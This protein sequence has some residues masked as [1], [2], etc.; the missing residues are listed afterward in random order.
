VG[1]RV[2]RRMARGR[3]CAHK[4]D[5]AS[6]CRVG[7]RRLCP[8]AYDPPAVRSAGAASWT[9]VPQGW[10]H[11]TWHTCCP[12]VLPQSRS[13]RIFCASIC[14][15]ARPT[16]PHHRGFTIRSHGWLRWRSCAWARLH[17]QA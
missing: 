10:N 14:A 12:S 6:H 1:W 16:A 8:S 9:G 4:A 2:G 7:F 5:S 3:S 13:G 17:G 15:R 11:E